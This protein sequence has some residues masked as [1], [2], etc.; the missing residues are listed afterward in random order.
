MPNDVK[1][2]LT[3]IVL[4]SRWFSTASLTTTWPLYIKSKTVYVKSQND[5]LKRRFKNDDVLIASFSTLRACNYFGKT[6]EQF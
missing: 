5:A 4:N 2:E 6:M 1:M 3:Q